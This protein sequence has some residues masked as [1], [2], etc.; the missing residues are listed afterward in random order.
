MNEDDFDEAWDIED[1]ETEAECGRWDN[2][3]LATGC[4]LAGTEFCDWNCP[5]AK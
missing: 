3:R 1:D 4:I 5:H 2:G